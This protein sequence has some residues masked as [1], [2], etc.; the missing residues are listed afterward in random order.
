MRMER[1]FF[2]EVKDMVT[3]LR[4]EDIEPSSKKGI[5]P[6]LVDWARKEL[7]T[8]FVVL[9]HENSIHILNAVSPG[10]TGSMAFAE[11]IVEK[12]TA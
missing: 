11:F 6:Q 2:A 8:D 1:N 10:F 3:D 7:V 12:Y 5:R 4:M 9:K